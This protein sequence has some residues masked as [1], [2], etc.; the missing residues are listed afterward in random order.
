MKHLQQ[1]TMGV[2]LML[3]SHLSLWAQTS[4]DYDPN[5]PPEPQN[6]FMLTLGVS[7]QSAGS[8]SGGGSFAEAARVWI[9]AYANTGFRFLHW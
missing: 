8:V 9:Q 4:P 3:C 1:L 5:N 2:L 7:E 6:L